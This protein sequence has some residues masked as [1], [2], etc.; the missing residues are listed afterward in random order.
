MAYATWWRDNTAVI[1]G[2]NER[3]EEAEHKTETACWDYISDMAGEEIRSVD[4]A[5]T[6][7]V[8]HPTS[9]FS[10]FENDVCIVD[11][12]PDEE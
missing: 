12:F 8:A 7:Q 2:G 11:G 6:W 3:I 1:G 10:I 9:S 5:I 4:D